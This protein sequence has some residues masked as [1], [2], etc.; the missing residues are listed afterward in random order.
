M[1]SCYYIFNCVGK[2]LRTGFN[3]RHLSLASSSRAKLLE[4]NFA[5]PKLEVLNLSGSATDDDALYA[6]SMSCCGLLQLNLENC[7]DVTEKGV[8][9]VVEKCTK[10]REINLGGC[11]N[12]AGNVVSEMVLSMPSLRK[13]TIPP[14]YHPSDHER[15]L[16]LHHRCLVC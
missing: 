8:R 5:V 10:L 16:F 12:V 2:V 7:Y 14:F 4:M 13:I 3:I 11:Q 6:I 9:Q 1:S 15:E